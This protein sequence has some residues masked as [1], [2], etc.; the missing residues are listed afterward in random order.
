MDENKAKFFGSA[1]FTRRDTSVT[2]VA[3]SVVKSECAYFFL[4]LWSQFRA[5]QLSVGLQKCV[6]KQ[7]Y[8]YVKS[9]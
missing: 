2:I 7:F 1:L 6:T 9:S 5:V 3:F 4:L 8:F